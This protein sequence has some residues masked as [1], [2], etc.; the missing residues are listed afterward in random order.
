MDSFVWANDSQTI[1]YTRQ[2]PVN[3]N[4]FQVYRH[5]LGDT[6]PDPLLYE[7][8][9]ET[10]WLT[11]ASSKSGKYL[12]LSSGSYDAY[13][14]RF[15]P[16]DNPDQPFTLLLDRAEGLEAYVDHQGDR[17]LLLTNLDAFNFRLLAAPETS[18][19]I[20]NWTEVVPN[21]TGAFFD[22][23]DAFEKHLALYGFGN[24]MRQVW[25]SNLATG[26]LTQVPF[27]E[28][29]HAVY[30]DENREYATNLLRV[31]YT[32]LVT[33]TI[34]YE[35]NVDS[36]EK[37]LLKQ[38]LVTDYDP[39]AYVVER[40]WATAPDGTKM[41]M[42][43]LTRREF[44]GKGPI[45]YA[46]EAYGAYGASYDP[47]YSPINAPLYDRGIG[48]A[49]AHVRGGSE[50]GRPWYDDGRLL[51]KMNTFTDFVACADHLIA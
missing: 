15:L 29:V 22:G 40:T 33:P 31:T 39:T 16:A 25:I 51:H 49:I 43:L 28:E 32:S 35:I 6:T 13:E 3:L 50:L 12:F 23:F 30:Q 8:A 7:E 48:F 24:G 38:E 4:P 10:F 42:S 47:Y 26:E 36:G 11:L 2:D 44:H 18:P 5:R 34:L 46:M 14:I 37:T 27:A 1:F 17:F 9:D 41:P 20:E 45:P 21:R 19:G